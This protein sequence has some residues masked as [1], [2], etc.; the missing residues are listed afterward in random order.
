LQ[1]Q[2]VFDSLVEA[3]ERGVKISIVQNSQSRAF[4]QD[5]SAELEKRGLAEVRSIDFPSI[6]GSGVLH[7][8][9]WIVDDK[10]IYVGSGNMD[11]RSLT[12]VWFCFEVI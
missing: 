7:T 5:D 9:F 3:G 6:F 2:R 8:K 4:P 12:E 11:W 1:G 10:H